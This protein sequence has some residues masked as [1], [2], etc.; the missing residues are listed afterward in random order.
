[1]KRSKINEDKLK[2]TKMMKT[3]HEEF[4]KHEEKT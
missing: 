4:K 3:K 2:T 1:M